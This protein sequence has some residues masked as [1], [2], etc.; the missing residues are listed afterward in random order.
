MAGIFYRSYSTGQSTGHCATDKQTSPKES[1]SPNH[2][3]EF[4]LDRREIV[5]LSYQSIKQ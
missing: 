2:Y 5:W 3:P 1:P 4:V